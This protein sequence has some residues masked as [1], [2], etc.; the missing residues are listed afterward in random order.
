MAVTTSSHRKLLSADERRAWSRPRVGPLLLHFF[1]VWAQIAVGWATYLL[2]PGPPALRFVAAFLLVAGGQHGL[3]LVTHEFAH[4]LVLPNRRRLN[5]LIGA[6]L[7]A[8][9]GGLAFDLYRQ[10]HF[11]HHRLFSTAD[12]TKSLYKRDYRGLRLILEVLR[13]LLAIDYLEQVVRVLRRA[14]RD[15]EEVRRANVSLPRALVPLAGS[16]AVIAVALI[17]IDPWLYLG[18]WLLPLLSLTPLLSKL[19]SSVE[20]LPLDRESGEAPEGPYYRGTAEPFVRSVRAGWLERLF[21]SKINFCYHEEHHLWP[22]I[23]YQYLPQ[24]RQRLQQSRALTT[25]EESYAST[26]WMFWRGL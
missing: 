22:Q 24:L 18:L 5:D 12:D 15:R 14:H 6:W 20:H 19:R 16:Q 3:G 26:L 25:R 7:F 13:S 4:Y 21:L 9:P 23:S 8:G 11:A 2:V 10:R 1:A 17:A